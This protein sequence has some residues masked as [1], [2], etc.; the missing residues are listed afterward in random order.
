MFSE[1]DVEGKQVPLKSFLLCNANAIFHTTNQKI[2]KNQNLTVHNPVVTVV[3]IDDYSK[4]D[5]DRSSS[6]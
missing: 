6:S 2:K 3:I 1:N 5:E 4:N